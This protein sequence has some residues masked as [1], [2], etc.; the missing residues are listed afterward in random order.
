MST[1]LRRRAFRAGLIG[2]VVV[3]YLALVGMIETFDARHLIEDVVNLSHVMLC[4]PAFAAAYLVVR[5]RLRGGVMTQPEKKPAI[6]A[7]VL[8]GA[9][10]GGLVMAGVA[11]TRMFNSDPLESIQAV[12][13]IFIQVSPRLLAIITFGAINP[14]VIPPVWDWAQAVAVLVLG[15][16][17]MGFLG[18]GLSVLPVRVRR[19]LST[20]LIVTGLFALLQRV[21]PNMLDKLQLNRDWLYSTR[22]GGLT[23]LG[24]VI[25][26]VVSTGV[27]A[28]WQVKGQEVRERLRGAPEEGWRGIGTMGRVLG[29]AAIAMLPFLLSTDRVNALDQVAIFVLM[30]LGL[31]IVVGFAGL[32]DLGYVAFF[33]VGA[34]MTALFTGAHVVTSLGA[35]A[36]PAFA[37]HLSFYVAVPLVVLTAAFVGV[38][39]GAP[40]LRLRGDYLAIV[41]LGFG[42]IARVLIVSDWLKPAVG[43]AQGLRDVTDA[44]I[45][46]FSFR[47][48]AHFYW[49]AL[50]FIIGA[51]YV[52]SRLANSRVGR[53]WN[54]MREDEQVAEAMGIS[55]I[56]FKLLAF[57]MGA[58]IGCLSGA[59]FAVRIGS[60]SGATF[61]I[62]V[63]ITVLAVII[64]GGMGSITGVIVGALVLIGLPEFLSEFETYKLLIYGA[65]LI[66]IMIL[67]PQGLVPNVRRMRELHEDE[68]EQDAWAKGAGE[69]TDA[70]IAVGATGTGTGPSGTVDAG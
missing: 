48:P 29:L 11:L 33:A 19:S 16:A 34:Y 47:D 23:R 51:I 3:I 43:G 12:R 32:L 64:L 50:V 18:A 61:G 4:L 2:G 55:T 36:D 42:E 45:A 56:K 40:V 27:A 30:A 5:P 54:A 49:L 38:I 41:T 37:L 13:N 6:M 1:E 24:S 52:S 59:L 17:A 70:T 58:A 46:G 22:F 39:I 10:A 65:A 20:G 26:F 15:G 68:V 21:I 35:T 28:L 31:N 67:R 44:S 14:V 57:A 60:L 62:L 25:V 66:A 63:S 53:A 9:V 7:G 69:A 8:A